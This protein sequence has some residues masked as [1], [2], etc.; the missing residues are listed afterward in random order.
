MVR[1]SVYSAMGR[2]VDPHGEPIEFHNWYN[3]G[4]GICYPVYGVVHIK[5]PLLL[6]EKSAP[7]SG[8]SGFPLS[9]RI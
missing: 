4:R 9:L 2:R 5:N 7:C 8:G 3:K 6:I 1:A